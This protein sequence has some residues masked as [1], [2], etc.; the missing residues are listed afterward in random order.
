MHR[1]KTL[2]IG[3]LT[4]F[5]VLYCA[6]LRADEGSTGLPSIGE[7]VEQVNQLQQSIAA[8]EDSGHINHGRA[9]SLSKKLDKVTNALT[10]S[11]GKEAAGDVSTQ[12]ASFLDELRGA[13]E[14]L[15][16]FLGELTELLTDLPAEVIQPIIDAAIELLRGL[17]ALLLG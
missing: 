9:T 10:S 8:L 12:Q 13:I 1:I 11:N 4:S 2:G 15:L 5:A 16:D 14:A 3:I 6:T 7:L 17:L